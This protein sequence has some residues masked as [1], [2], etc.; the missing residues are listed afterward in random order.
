MPHNTPTDFQ[1]RGGAAGLSPE[2]YTQVNE[3]EKF[4]ASQ[5]ERLRLR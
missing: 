5:C 1:D 3:Y 4:G 2:L